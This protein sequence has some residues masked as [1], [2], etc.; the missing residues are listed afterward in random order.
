MSY[1]VP[2]IDST[3]FHY[4]LYSDILESLIASYKNIYGQDVY[5]GN[6]AADYQWISDVALKLNDTLATLQ[7]VYNNR[8]PL[9]AIGTSLDGVVKINGITRKV[10]TYSTCIVTLTGTAGT[11]VLDGKVSDLS[12]NVWDLPAT[13]T[14]GDLGTADVSATC[15][16]IGAISALPDTITTIVNP[17]LGWFSVNNNVAAVLGLPIETDAQLRSRQSLSTRLAAHTMVAGTIAGIAA[18]ENV[19]RYNVHENNTNLYEPTTNCPP[20]SVTCV[21][22]GGTDADVAQAIYDNKGIGCDTYGGTTV[23]VTDIDTG[24]TFEINFSRPEYVPIYVDMTVRKLVGYSDAVTTQIEEA[25]AAYL[26]DLQIG[27][28]LAISSLYGAALA[29]MPDLTTPM[30]S[31]ILLE[32]GVT[33]VTGTNDITIDYDQVTQGILGSSPAYITVV[34]V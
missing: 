24:D 2:V 12:G 9:T 7:Y 33:N 26:N 17:Q 15:E 4:P 22:E 14:I 3:G 30:F 16:T 34:T 25:V 18:V 28:D 11:I 10:A 29:V 32:A 23:T 13:S 31:I 8:G 1:S 19:T 20:H 27:Q 21:V 5:L 6:D